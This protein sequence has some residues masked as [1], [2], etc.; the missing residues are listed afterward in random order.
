MNY[1][2]AVMLI[3]PNIR[4]IKVIYESEKENPRQSQYTFKTLDPT[5]AKD[6][7]VI[8]PT[9]TRHGMTVVKVAEVDVEIDFDS[10]VELKWAVDKVQSENYTTVLEQEAVWIEAI[11]AS[12]K[13]KKR[14]ELKKSMIDMYQDDGI[15]NLGIAKLSLTTAPALESKV[16]AESQ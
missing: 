2:S 5:I 10:N 6:D 8:V 16:V 12:E 4:A 9:D 7:L 15:E 13:R 3:N 14:E 11:K 1:S